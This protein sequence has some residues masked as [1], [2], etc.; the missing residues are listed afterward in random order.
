MRGP[1]VDSDNQPYVRVLQAYLERLRSAIARGPLLN[2]DGGAVGRG[3]LMDLTHLNNFHS[4]Q[5]DVLLDRLL[6]QRT[7]VRVQPDWREI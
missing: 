7:S 4:D 1:T 3:S 6:D 2:A 5:A